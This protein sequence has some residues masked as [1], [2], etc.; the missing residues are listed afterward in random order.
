[1]NSHAK[2]LFEI[3]NKKSLEFKMKF[4]NEIT[5][6]VCSFVCPGKSFEVRISTSYKIHP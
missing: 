2:I 1:M 5:S 3:I 6:T 4:K